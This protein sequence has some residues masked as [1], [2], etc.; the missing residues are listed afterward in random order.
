M[1]DGCMG[2][3]SQGEFLSFLVEALDDGPSVGQ[4]VV[5]VDICVVLD[6]IPLSPYEDKVGEVRIQGVVAECSGWG[7]FGFVLKLSPGS[8]SVVETA[9]VKLLQNPC[10]RTEATVQVDVAG[11]D[12]SCEVGTRREIVAEFHLDPTGVDL[13]AGLKGRL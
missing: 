4:Q 5:S 11:L 3:Q 12:A 1:D 2:V 13:L 8:G 10:L 6:D 7:G 9:G